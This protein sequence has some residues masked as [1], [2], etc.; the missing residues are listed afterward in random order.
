MPTSAALQPW[1]GTCCTGSRAARSTRAG[2]HAA[3]M[4][5]CVLRRWSPAL[6]RGSSLLRGWQLQLAMLHAAPVQVLDVLRCR[7]PADALRDSLL[8]AFQDVVGLNSD[9]WSARPLDQT[10]RPISS[11]QALS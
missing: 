10:H 9:G 4:A 8:A 3:C 2:S 5:M 1:A 11:P 7:S 6:H